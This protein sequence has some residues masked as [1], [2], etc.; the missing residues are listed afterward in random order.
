MKRQ[1]KTVTSLTAAALACT[2][3]LPFATSASAAVGDEAPDV[4]IAN[5]D[6]NSTKTGDTGRLADST[7]FARAT[8]GSAA[9][10]VQ[11]LDGTTALD[12]SGNNWL[13]VT[14]VTGNPL[15]T[16]L[17]DVTFSYDSKSGADPSWTIF[18][19]R[20]SGG[21]PWGNENYV[22]VL[23]RAGTIG[24]E[25]YSSGRTNNGNVSTQGTTAWKHIDL[26]VNNNETTLKVNGVTKA[27]NTTIDVQHALS[28]I[29][30]SSSI[31]R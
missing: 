12:M 5:F 2:M 28:T 19:S 29:L 21:V 18:A 24:V 25:R 20:D 14:D 30:G 27:T 16:G 17:N 9:Q 23:D 3:L 6:F 1:T 13:N 4:T 11:G 31:L 10:T 22:G 15:L 7:G 26:I 8:F